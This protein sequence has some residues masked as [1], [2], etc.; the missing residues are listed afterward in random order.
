MHPEDIEASEK[1]LFT[2]EWLLAVINRH[3][4]H[5]DFAL[6][7]ISYR[8]P[9]VLG[10]SYGAAIASGKLDE[11]SHA[12]RKAFRKTDLVA[13]DGTDFWI[14]VP[15]TPVN[16]RLVDKIRYIADTASQC[17]LQIVDRDISIFALSQDLIAP[18]EDFSAAEFLRYLKEKHVALAHQEVSLP[19]SD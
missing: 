9:T 18:R 15:Y 11:F 4:G 19:N 17:G 14:L 1:F 16:E 3:S 2:L 10:E 13:R 8:N 7:H 6:A 5:F 12:L